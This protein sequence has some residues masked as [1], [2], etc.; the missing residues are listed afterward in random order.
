MPRQAESR[1]LSFIQ[2]IVNS[3]NFALKWEKNCK[4][5]NNSNKKKMMDYI[6]TLNKMFSSPTE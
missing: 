2:D 4:K 3:T 1:S 6:E 5:S